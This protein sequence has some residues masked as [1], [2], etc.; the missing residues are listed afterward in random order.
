MDEKVIENFQRTVQTIVEKDVV[1]TDRSNPYFRGENNPN[2]DVLKL[3]KRTFTLT[4]HFAIAR[5]R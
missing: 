5:K 1:R 3:V 4:S 2:I